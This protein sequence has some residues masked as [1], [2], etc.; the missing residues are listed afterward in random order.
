MDILKGL[1]RFRMRISWIVILLLL[2]GCSQAE[3]KM[4]NKAIVFETNMG[5]FEVELY[6]DK[7][8]ITVDNFLSY[9]N[10]GFYDGLIFHR[11]ISDFMIQGGGFDQEL[12]Q[13]ETKGPIKNE[14]GNGL[15]NEKYT[16][17]MART[18]VVDSAT[19]QFF[20]NV[21]DNAFLDHTDETSRG[22]G[23]AVFGKVISGTSVVDKIKSVKTA[24]KNGFDDVP[25][26]PV[27]IKKAYVK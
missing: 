15:K 5:N 27:I 1:R 4:K 12:I 25:V 2:V 19:S 21:A 3:D 7:A 6:Q 9:V 16:I 17:A 22:Y 26:D 24:T 18:M 11:I 8:P 10:E 23:Y 14:A 13:K 20:I